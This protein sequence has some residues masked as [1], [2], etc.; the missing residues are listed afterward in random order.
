MINR[1]RT[2]QGYLFGVAQILNLPYRRFVIGR[3]LLAGDSSQVKNLRYSRLQVC[4]TDTASTLNRYR[5][6]CCAILVSLILCGLV[7]VQAQQRGTAGGGR[8]AGQG[9]S[10]STSGG[11]REYYGNGEV[12]DAMITV[13][14]DTR[15]LVII[16]DDETSQYISQ[17][18][19]NL[20]RPRPQVLIKVV[21]LEVTHRDSLDIGIEG[22]GTHP[23]N[24]IGTGAG[25][26]GF[27]LSGLNTAATNVPVNSL[28]L[29][30]QS[31][32]PVPP[33]AGVYQVLGSD[34][35][36]TLRAIA[37]AGKTEVLSRP[38]IL[39]RNNQQATISLG[40]QVPL[41][42]NTRFDTLGNQI[43]TV[44]YQSVGIILR[45]T[46]FITAD[47]MVEM[48]VSP[49]TSALADRSQWVPIS[50][51][52][53]GSITAPVIDSRTA[54]TVVVVPDGQTAVIG[55]LME[56]NKLQ[57]DSKIPVLG[58]IP[59]LGYLFKRKVKQTTKTEL[60]IFLTPHIV[61]EPAQ[62]A[63]VSAKERSGATMVP[64]AFSEQELDRFL[65]N[66]PAKENPPP[67]QQRK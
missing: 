10:G 56:N 8:T 48:I 39:T 30:V 50:S 22:G 25:A 5:Q 65:E 34:F 15:R 37:Q 26:T 66:V 57:S 28:G 64:K 16:T 19:S 1:N 20:D 54:D 14:P 36:A 53:G 52:P 23:V 45:V 18:V 9:R 42:T 4:A 59:V 41:I 61:A 60:I 17:V 55:G 38:S 51:G 6:G 11:S 2:R 62:L 24:G 43:N 7:Q 44:T 46:P 21:F 35:Q 29:P 67:A 40:Q 47:G 58:D 33:G 31:F 27:G 13:D 32:L 12:G 63:G 49:E 3:T